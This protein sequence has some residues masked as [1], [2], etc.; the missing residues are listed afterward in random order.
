MTLEKVLQR[1]IVIAMVACSY[2]CSINGV[3]FLESSKVCTHSKEFC[4]RLT[5]IIA[6]FSPI[7]KEVSN[8]WPRFFLLV[9]FFFFSFLQLLAALC[10]RIYLFLW[11]KMEL[12]LS[13]IR[14]LTR[15]RIT[16][17]LSSNDIPLSLLGFPKS[18]PRPDHPWQ[19]HSQT[20]ERLVVIPFIS[21]II[22]LIL[23]VFIK[24][25]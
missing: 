23:G 9:Y 11:I 10:L 15:S 6:K 17:C 18:H 22:V 4:Q 24:A 14:H 8:L 20:P 13:P 2:H 21:R 7:S 3:L 5:E 25:M 1:P 16:Y 12:S 19:G